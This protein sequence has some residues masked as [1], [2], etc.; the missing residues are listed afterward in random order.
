M[1]DQK[2]SAAL[3]AAVLICLAGHANAIDFHW[4][5][6]D[7]TNN[8]HAPLN[9]SPGST[10][11]SW[12]DGTNDAAL[13][14][15][16]NATYSVDFDNSHA[17]KRFEVRVGN[18]TIF[19]E[20]GSTPH[21]YTLHTTTEAAAIVSTFPGALFTTTLTIDGTNHVTLGQ[22]SVS[23]IQVLQIAVGD[24]TTKGILSLSNVNWGSTAASFVGL[25]GNGVLNIASNASM[26]SHSGVLGFTGQS[27][28]TADISGQWVNTVGDLVVGKSGRGTLNIIGA[29]GFVHTST[30]HISIAEMPGSIGT[31]TL[32]TDGR[33]ESDGSLYVGGGPSGPGGSGS[34][35]S[36]GFILGEEITV[37]DDLVIYGNGS[38]DLDLGNRMYV[39]NDT[40]IHPGGSLTLRR[41]DFVTETL[42]GPANSVTWTEDELFV[43]NEVSIDDNAPL[44]GNVSVSSFFNQQ[45]STNLLKVGPTAGG[46]LSLSG[47]AGGGIVEIG[48]LIPGTDPATVTLVNAAA[49][50]ETV[51][52]DVRGATQATLNVQG[53]A[54]VDHLF[55]SRFA[56]LPGT[57]A[58]VNI[59]NPGTLWD[60]R[61]ALYIGGDL[62]TPGGNA[63]VT[64][65]DSATVQVNDFLKLWPGANMTVDNATLTID[66][67]DV[68]GTL[69]L[70]DATFNINAATDIDVSG[71]LTLGTTNTFQ[72][73]NLTIT[74]GGHVDFTN[75]FATVDALGSGNIDRLFLQ[76]GKLSAPRVE[77]VSSTFVGYGHLDA[78]V[79]A[80][81]GVLATGDL[82]MGRPTVVNAVQIS[83]SVAFT[84]GAHH[85]TL[86]KTGFW[87]MH[88]F[89]RILGGTLSVATGVSMRSGLFFSGFGAIDGRMFI[90]GGTVIEADGG[91]LAIGDAASLAGFHSDGELYTGPNTVTIHDANEA[92]LGTLTQLGDGVTPGT[93]AAP[94]GLLVEFG[95]N[96]AGHGTVDTPNDPGSPLTN[97]GTIAGDSPGEPI[98][99]NGYVKGIGTFANIVV[100]GTFAPGLSPGVVAVE[101]SLVVSPTGTLQIELAGSTTSS[102]HDQ[103]NVTGDVTLEGTLDVDLLLSYDP[104]HGE[105][106][107]VLTWTGARNG[108]FD[109]FDGLDLS[110]DNT[111]SLA[112]VFDDV[113]GEL[114]LTAAIPGDANLDGAVTLEDLVRLAASF[115]TSPGLGSWP[116]G[117]FDHNGIVNA[118]DLN[119]MAGNFTGPSDTLTAIATSLGV[120]I[121]QTPEPGTVATVGV[122]CLL[123]TRRRKKRQKPCLGPRN[124]PSRNDAYVQ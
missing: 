37:G 72:I 85:V 86:L 104:D 113:L 123:A 122:G 33:L 70:T 124:V 60:G 54:E 100:N 121:T 67:L 115:D 49:L 68:G 120:T 96:I 36:T 19:L 66:N 50:L 90:D 82:I 45:L 52:V 92:V 84:V 21:H 23:T 29:S 77:F 18:P 13:F 48:S 16:L 32:N 14:D 118:N 107:T 12:P 98:T 94:N 55:S 119:L 44:G 31:V 108:T 93:L 105:S 102:E 15:T 24:S 95:K 25:N 58:V 20:T 101:T 87:D 46:T 74:D 111:K 10:S 30:G 43:Q 2:W 35:I 56:G 62:N 106:F 26:S 79:I 40:I 59:T 11:T 110:T 64:V 103:V 17:N 63:T 91:D 117:D 51:A 4:T 53:G 99:L 80:H 7:A 38:V 69:T 34:L 76:G 73:P 81:K 42:T 9:W 8:F 71:T 78:V 6:G 27:I 75:R 114:T 109:A 88:S 41:G 3:G 65:S 28:G 47:T 22:S 1:V 5:G 89:T 116:L 61:A 112:A 39:E 57:N 83:E 97:L